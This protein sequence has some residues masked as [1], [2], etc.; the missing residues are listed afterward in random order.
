MKK[1]PFSVFDWHFADASDESARSEA[2]RERPKETT[3]LMDVFHAESLVHFSLWS[4]L[5]AGHPVRELWLETQTDLS[6]SVY[7]AYGGFFRQALG[8]LRTWFE[9]VVH[10]VYFSD[11]YGQP[12]GRYEQWRRGLRN[13]PAKMEIIAPSLATR[14]GRNLNIDSSMLLNELKPIYSLLCDQAH[15]SGL[16]MYDLQE[17]RDNVPRYLPK[18]FELWYRAVLK[19]FDVACFIYRIFFVEQVRRYLSAA[20]RE[21]RRALKLANELRAATPHLAVLI[22]EALNLAPE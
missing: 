3:V 15:G 2:V 6:A 19:T 10:S 12:T 21:G 9:L 20:P 16:D 5:P 1:D 17:D 18:S 13:A 11:H 4:E 22:H 14:A 7:L 8:V